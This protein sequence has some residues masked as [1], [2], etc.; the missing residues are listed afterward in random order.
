LQVG[1]RLP[2][3]E[4]R[5]HRRALRHRPGRPGGLGQVCTAA[6][7]CASWLCANDD[8][9]QYGVED[10]RPGQCPSGFG[11]RD[12][13]MGGGVCWPGFHEG[14]GCTAGGHDSPIGALALG[15]GFAAA[16]RR[17]RISARPR[18][19]PPPRR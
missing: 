19:A 1:R 18:S 4:Q 15:L 3:S 9:S 6:T 12:D 7:D 14:A 16:V 17:R 8:G 13:G 10:C 5:L 11:C 2:G